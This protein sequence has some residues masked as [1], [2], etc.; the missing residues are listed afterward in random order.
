MILPYFVHISWEDTLDFPKPK[1][2]KK[3]IPK[4]KLLVKG[5][6]YLPEYVGEILDASTWLNHPSTVKHIF[7]T[8]VQPQTHVRT[9]STTVR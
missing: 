2:R 9:K 4:P 1:Q 7:V 5:P 3:G 8:Y 6:G